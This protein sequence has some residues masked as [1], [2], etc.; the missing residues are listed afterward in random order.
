MTALEASL[1]T[2]VENCSEDGLYQRAFNYLLEAYYKRCTS[3]H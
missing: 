2:P 3:K 1:E